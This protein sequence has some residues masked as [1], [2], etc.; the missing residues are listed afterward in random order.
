M[1]AR[2]VIVDAIDPLAERSCTG[3]RPDDVRTEYT[4]TMSDLAVHPKRHRIEVRVTP[5]QDALIRE[6]ADLADETVTSFVLD[7]VT[8]RAATLIDQHRDVVL[9]HKAYEDFI[10]AL[11]AP[12]VPVPELSSLFRRHKKLP[13]A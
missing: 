6:A 4:E 12:A 9:S 11:D 2:L 3:E 1:T 10:A 7:T 13:E 8:A 5:E